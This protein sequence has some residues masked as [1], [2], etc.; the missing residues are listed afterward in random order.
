M[1][2]SEQRAFLE[3]ITNQI[4]E[5][6]GSP[7]IKMRDARLKELSVL[8]KQKMSFSK[9][10][11]EFYGQIEQVHKDFQIKLSVRFPDLTENE[12]RLATLLR[13]N[14]STKEIATFMNISP[15]SVEIARYR[16]RKKL[17]LKAGENMTQFLLDL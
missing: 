13:L 4:S 6:I 9:E 1:N 3:N 8:L 10:I 14:F 2:I 7:D 17:D 15:K 12:K 16:L 5:L 11:D